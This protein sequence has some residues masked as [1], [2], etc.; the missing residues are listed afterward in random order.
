MH[1]PFNKIVF[2]RNHP[3]VHGK[4]AKVVGLKTQN[5]Y[6]GQCS[7]LPKLSQN[8]RLAFENITQTMLFGVAELETQ[9]YCMGN[10]A[11]LLYAFPLARS[12]PQ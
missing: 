6:Y 1:Y 2:L 11:L 3:N 5:V 8:K 10:W 9:I 7:H 4:I 12:H